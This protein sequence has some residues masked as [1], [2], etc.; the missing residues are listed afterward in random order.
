MVIAM[1]KFG[2]I[3]TSRQAGREAL[4]A[5]QPTL[6]DAK[7]DGRIILNF[8]G[9]FSL[10]PSWA[11]EFLRPLLEQF[12]ERVAVKRSDNASV[13]QTFKLLEGIRQK[14]FPIV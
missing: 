1:K 7:P 8:E 4:L 13:T 12:G 2:T 14:S 5:F 9:V 6:N 10:S 11:D 3:L